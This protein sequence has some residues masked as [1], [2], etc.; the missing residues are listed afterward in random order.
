MCF[1]IRPYPMLTEVRI[2]EM[3]LSFRWEEEMAG[4][5]R[6]SD[7]N[8]RISDSTEYKQANLFGERTSYFPSLCCGGSP[9]AAWLRS[10]GTNI[11]LNRQPIQGT[12][13]CSFSSEFGAPFQ[14]WSF[15]TPIQRVRVK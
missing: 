10:I 5:R 11:Q 8:N 15:I 1:S 6:S 7:G 13:R 9:H 3:W 12:V 4:I 14:P 2:S